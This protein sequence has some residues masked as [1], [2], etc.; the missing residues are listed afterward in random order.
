MRE[1]DHNATIS[2]LKMDSKSRK[3]RNLNRCN[4]LDGKTW[5]QYSISV[6]NDIKKSSEEIKISHPAMFP[7]QLTDRLIRIFTREEEK[8]ILDPF[9]GSGSTIIAAKR[10][11]KEGIG[12]EISEE[13][14]KIAEDRLMQKELFDIGEGRNYKI[15][16]ADARELLQYL[17][18][19]SVDMCLTSPPYW[20]ILSQKRTADYKDVRDY[21]DTKEDL[22]KIKDYRKFIDALQEVFSYVFEVLKDGKYCIIIVMDIRKKAKF[23]PFHIDIALMMQEVGFIFDDIII[24]DRRQEY[25]NLR[26]LGYPY[27]FRINKVHEYILIFQKPRKLVSLKREGANGL[28]LPDGIRFGRR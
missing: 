10:V 16:R 4:E 27:V 17:K 28:K 23:Y 14:I 25:N 11:G 12:F 5:L 9:M 20:D 7:L 8:V 2:K 19:N 18:P 13:F 24:W 22:G 1:Y 15:Y 21:G 6:W 3:D 26:P